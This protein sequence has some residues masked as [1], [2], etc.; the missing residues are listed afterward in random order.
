MK[1]FAIHS[2][3][4]FGRRRTI[5]SVIFSLSLLFM[6]ITVLV[7]I[8]ASINFIASKACYQH[9]EID[10]SE[11]N[12]S[13][14]FLD[15]ILFSERQ[16][17]LGKSIFFHET[18]CLADNLVRLNAR[19]VSE[20]VRDNCQMYFLFNWFQFFLCRQACAIESAA[21]WNPN[22]DVFLLFASPVGFMRSSAQNAS[23]IHALMS[24]PNVA[25]RN[26]HLW[27]YTMGTPVNDWLMRGALFGS[28]YLTSHTSDLLR[29]LSLYKFG[30]IYMD[31][32][33]V[34]QKSFENIEPNFTGAESSKD[35]AAGV[36]SFAHTGIGHDVA[37]MCIKWVWNV[38]AI[39]L[40][41]RT[42]IGVY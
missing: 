8:N 23:V 1:L 33:V 19:W 9:K 10:G 14:A 30:G 4:N 26:V 41:T 40:A 17:R 2:S 6:I 12:G 7:N 27:S 32:D 5:F 21:K 18:S 16:P 15:D 29:Y 20:C 42:K 38:E 28:K 36:M 31:L 35:I 37:G 13:I 39:T 34:V 3:M 24:Y 22:F 25:M 11:L